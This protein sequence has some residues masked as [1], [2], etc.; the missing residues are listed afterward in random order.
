MGETV[1]NGLAESL[2][3]QKYGTNLN[4]VFL[5]VVTFSYEIMT[6]YG[7]SKKEHVLRSIRIIL[8]VT[9]PPTHF[10]EVETIQS[11]AHDGNS[12]SSEKR[13][14]AVSEFLTALHLHRPKD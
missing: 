1:R 7:S 6:Y 4:M 3:N 5:S 2:I 10:Q 13:P 11:K 8:R 14:F 9:E 12:Y